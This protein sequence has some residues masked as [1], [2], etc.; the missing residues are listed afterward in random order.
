MRAGADVD[1]EDKWGM[2]P[3]MQACWCGALEAVEWL[4]NNGAFIDHRDIVSSGLFW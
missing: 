3:L 1:Y 4:L 2:T